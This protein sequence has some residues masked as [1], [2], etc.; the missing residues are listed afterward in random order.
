MSDQQH[1]S[2][3]QRFEVTVGH[4]TVT[5]E[6]ATKDEAVE[7]ARRQMCLELPRMWDVIHSL[8]D[9]RFQVSRAA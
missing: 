1:Q 5:V 2:E 9:E 8:E 4:K 7:M 6:C 3:K